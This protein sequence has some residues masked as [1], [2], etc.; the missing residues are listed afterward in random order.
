MSAPSPWVIPAP[1][2]V[3]IAGVADMVASNDRSAELVTYSLGSCL[4]VAIYD[5]VTKVGGLLHLM[6]PDSSINPAKGVTNPF[7]FVDTGV[8]QLFHAVYGMGGE[9][10]RL[11]VKVAGGAQFLDEKKIFNIGARN[12]TALE[13]ILARNGVRTSASDVGGR[14]SRTVRLDLS[15]GRLSIQVPG[16]EIYSL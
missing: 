8:P 11:I 1:R 16:S 14:I 15:T 7:M 9:K 5:P 12:W 4:G 10:S 2:K 3:L 13:E 6:L